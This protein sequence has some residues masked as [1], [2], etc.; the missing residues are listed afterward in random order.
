MKSD[1]PTPGGYPAV[2]AQPKQLTDG[3]SDGVGVNDNLKPEGSDDLDAGYLLRNDNLTA[4]NLVQLMN[5]PK[6]RWLIHTVLPFPEPVLLF[7]PSGCGKTFVVLDMALSLATGLPFAEIPTVQVGV[8][9]IATE[10]ASGL[11]KRITAWLIHHRLADRQAQIIVAEGHVDLFSDLGTDKLIR[12]VAA[13]QNAAG[14]RF[15]LIVVDTL[16]KA[17]G[18]GKEN[19][20]SDITRITLNAQRVSEAVGAT[21]L[22]VHHTGKSEDAGARGGSALKAN[23]ATSLAL[24]R[25]KRGMRWLSFDK[26][27]DGDDSLEFAVRLPQHRVGID[28]K[29]RAITS[30]VA[31]ILPAESDPEEDGDQQSEMACKML[32]LVEEAGPA[33]ILWSDITAHSEFAPQWKQRAATVREWKSELLEADLVREEGSSRKTRLFAVTQLLDTN[34]VGS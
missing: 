13:L 11:A 28:E 9:Y 34:R 4:Y 16:A 26:Q 14:V 6:Q 10:G 24:R 32:A 19:D 23:V 18:N 5:R 3:S 17:M 2:S 29:G 27:K 25:G 15:R 12:F 20:N 31:V 1:H 7:G 8:L 30:C 21:L 22:L 33:G